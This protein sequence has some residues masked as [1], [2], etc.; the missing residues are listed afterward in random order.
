MQLIYLFSRLTGMRK[1]VCHA[2]QYSSGIRL[3]F[4]LDG[5]PLTTGGMTKKKV[6]HKGMRLASTNV[7]AKIPISWCLRKKIPS[8]L[9]NL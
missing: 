9:F 3:V 6:V 8:T 7:G 5:S 1:K 4:I 2:R